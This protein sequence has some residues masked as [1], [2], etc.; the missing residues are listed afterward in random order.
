M[1][2]YHYDNIS[3]NID[4]TMSSIHSLY[5]DFYREIEKESLKQNDKYN[6]LKNIIYNV[7]LLVQHIKPFLDCK[8]LHKNL[9]NIFLLIEYKYKLISFNDLF[10][11]IK[12]LCDSFVEYINF[13]LG[14][15]SNDI[16]ILYRNNF[17]LFFNN[18]ISKKIKE[19]IYL[20]NLLYEQNTY[21]FNIFV[22]NNDMKY[23]KRKNYLFIV[24]FYTKIS[25]DYQN[26]LV[27][28]FGESLIRDL[29][30]KFYA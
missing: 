22:E 23:L 10:G 26:P 30:C 19:D 9:S 5:H 18:F 25:K 14:D 16:I 17:K 21:F 4:R 12:V 20:F 6:Y 13:F 15:V 27:K 28:C 24:F 8:Y 7:F 3:L 11:N 1:I 29:I 2:I